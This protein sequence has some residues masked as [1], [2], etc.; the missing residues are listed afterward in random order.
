MQLAKDWKTVQLDLPGFPEGAQIIDSV[1]DLSADDVERIKKKKP[2]KLGI[3][4]T[5][6]DCKRNL[7]C[8]GGA[9]NGVSPEGAC[10]ACGADLIDWQTVCTR[11]STDFE[12]KFNFLT[13]EWI[14]HFFFHVPVTARIEL[15]ARKHG[16]RGLTAITAH[17]LEQKKILRYMPAQD[18]KQTPMLDGTIVHWAR[19]ATASCCRA[20]MR[21]W[22][23]IP[24]TH[25]LL[26]KDVDYF[27]KLV[28]H[29]IQMRM[30]DLGPR[31]K[32]VMPAAIQG[33]Q[34]M[35]N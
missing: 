20:C 29:Y 34:A 16:Y 13:K 12:A 9:R 31:K 26:D 4:C 3:V 23:G 28:M 17:Q 14:R 25:E 24:L 33:Q 27:T 7:H 1:F 30:P 21:Y 11:E 2:K 35:A 6:S 10:R 15:Y 5:R 32:V 18:W 22:H 8:F 19:H